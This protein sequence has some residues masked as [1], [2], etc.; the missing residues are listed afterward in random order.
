MATPGYRALL[1]LAWP[2]VLA[3]S[4]QAVIGF[5][6]AAMVAPLGEDALAATTAAATNTMAVFILPMGIVFIVQSFAAQ[7]AGKR[8]LD[9]ARRYAYYAL[10]LAALTLLLSAAAIPGLGPLVEQLGFTPEVR[11]L[12]AS[13]MAIR[14]FAAGAVVGVEGLGNWYAGLGDTRV[15]MVTN[16]IAMI[17]NVFLNWV[18]IYGNLG[19][20]A[21]GVE[22]A[23][24]ASVLASWAS[25]ASVAAYFAIDRGRRVMAELAANPDAEAPVAE[26]LPA[27]LAAELAAADDGRLSLAEFRR[28]IRFG[29]PNGFNWFLEFS[30]F[31]V[32]INVIFADLGTAAVAALMAVIQVNSVSFMPAFGLATAGAILVGQ[33]IGRDAHLDVPR[34]VA[35]TISLTMTWQGLVGLSYLLFPDALMA[36][37]AADPERASES[38]VTQLGATLLAISAAWQ[39]FDAMVMGLSEALRAAGDT[40]WCL[41]ARIACAWLVWLPATFVVIRVYDGGAPEAVWCMVSYFVLLTGVIGWRFR[42]GAWRQIDLTGDAAAP[43]ET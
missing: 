16:L 13:Y 24:W 39:L 22:G 40:A 4:A 15:A 5:S 19:A 27:E 36:V 6:D 37:F 17:V 25:F 20:P 1:S 42:S 33:A 7:L 43:R 11:A 12:M 26:E 32:F 29:M 41:W 21:L 31:L 14:F 28:M 34:I 10:L 9:G 2:I 18:L 23:A 30:A 8:D 3:R 38:A 35:K